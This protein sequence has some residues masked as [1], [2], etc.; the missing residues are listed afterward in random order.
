ML[1]LKQEMHTDGY[2]TVVAIT[3]FI[4]M[5]S[6]PLASRRAQE[7]AAAPPACLTVSIPLARPSQRDPFC[8]L[9]HSGSQFPAAPAA[10]HGRL[11]GTPVGCR[12]PASFH[13][14]TLCRANHS[15]NALTAKLLLS[16]LFSTKFSY[17]NPPVIFFTNKIYE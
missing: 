12:D 15:L 3:V 6:S 5:A 7:Q 13:L 8:I 4:C 16:L 10:V 9:S 2:R 14:I 11:K 1:K 17:D